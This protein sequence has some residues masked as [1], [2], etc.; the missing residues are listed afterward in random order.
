MQMLSATLAES[1]ARNKR[2]AE[3]RNVCLP[4]RLTWKDAR[5]TMR[6]ATAVARNVS[7][8]GVFVEC[9]TPVSIPL[10]RLVHLQIERD[11]GVASALPAALVRGRVLSAVYR[12]SPA[13][14]SKRQ[15][16][17]LRLMVDPRTMAASEQ[18]RASA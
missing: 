9:L 1:R 11:N 12:V 3:R 5:G 15:G 18:A 13:S 10:Y 4:A 8:F 7:E 16:L 17:A 6:F 14:M 2:T